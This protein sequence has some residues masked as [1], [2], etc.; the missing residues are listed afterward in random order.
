M[1]LMQ[2]CQK[3]QWGMPSYTKI[4][5]THRLESVEITV[6][7]YGKKKSED[8]EIGKH[9]IVVPLVYTPVNTQEARNCVAI[10][11][12]M[13]LFPHLKLDFMF[14]QPYRDV[15]FQLQKHRANSPHS[16]LIF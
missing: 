13:K 1:V 16:I 4:P 3:A 8:V 6:P 5:D 14:Q 11:A 7:N 9:R 12:L 10:V 15:H 2:Q